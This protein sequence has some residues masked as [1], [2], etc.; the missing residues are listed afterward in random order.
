MI[1]LTDRF[2]PRY[3]SRD[4]Q[5][6]YHQIWD[7]REKCFNPDYCSSYVYDE[8]EDLVWITEQCEIMNIEWR[9]YNNLIYEYCHPNGLVFI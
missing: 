3:H 9:L 7:R 5:F 6:I 2:E 1:L 4:D 8:Q